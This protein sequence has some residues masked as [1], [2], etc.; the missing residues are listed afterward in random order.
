MGKKEREI[1]TNHENLRVKNLKRS[2]PKKAKNL[3]R[4]LQKNL[5]K[6]EGR[7]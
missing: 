3:K 6:R 2:H 5:R 7:L 4:S 1:E